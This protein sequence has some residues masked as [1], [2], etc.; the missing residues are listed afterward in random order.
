MNPFP[1]PLLCLYCDKIILPGNK[2]GCK[3]HMLEC[4]HHPAAGFVEALK[5]IHVLAAPI[6]DDEPCTHE[7]ER[8][9]LDSRREDIFAL[10]IEALR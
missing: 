4:K 10:A 3:Q 7:E 9:L 2:E 8:D 5:K 6:R 1:S